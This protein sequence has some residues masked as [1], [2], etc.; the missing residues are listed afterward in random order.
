MILAFL[1]GLAVATPIV[2]LVLI[3]TARKPENQFEEPGTFLMPDGRRLP[4]WN[5]ESVGCRIRKR[6][7]IPESEANSKARFE[8]KRSESI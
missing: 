2:A 1:L 5:S 6:E 7:G 4:Y 8:N 3:M